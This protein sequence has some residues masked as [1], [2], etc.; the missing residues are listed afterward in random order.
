M[1][2]SP[3]HTLLD[4][5]DAHLE[6]ASV[7][8]SRWCSDPHRGFLGMQ[9]MQECLKKKWTIRKVKKCEGSFWITTGAHEYE[10]ILPKDDERYCYPE[11]CSYDCFHFALE[12]EDPLD[13]KFHGHLDACLHGYFKEALGIEAVVASLY[14]RTENRYG[15]F[16]EMLLG[17]ND[18]RLLLVHPAQIS[19]IP[20][21]GPVAFPRRLARFPTVESKVEPVSMSATSIDFEHPVGAAKWSAWFGYGTFAF[22]GLGLVTCIVVIAKVWSHGYP[23]S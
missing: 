15:L 6:F 5:L 2:N 13:P 16:L 4:N 22:F 19:R 12:H 23:C 10:G 11:I 14:N 20:N 8:P 17:P 9:G 1:K 7:E 18:L 3:N 21:L